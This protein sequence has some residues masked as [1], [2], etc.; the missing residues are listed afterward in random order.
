MPPSPIS[1]RFPDRVNRLSARIESD[2]VRSI[3]DVATARLLAV[4]VAQARREERARPVLA[5]AMLDVVD[6]I[7]ASA[8]YTLSRSE[9]G[10]DILVPAGANVVVGMH[11]AQVWSLQ[12]SD[13]VTLVPHRGVM[14][15]RGVQGIFAAKRPGSAILSLTPR[16]GTMGSPP[17]VFFITVVPLHR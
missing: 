12:N 3:I 9:N 15:V 7:L 13:P 4:D 2:A 5:A 6:R 16:D 8:D 10:R 11:D 1:Q 17:V 14:F